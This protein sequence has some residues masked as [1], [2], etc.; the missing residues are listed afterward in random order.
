MGIYIDDKLKFHI[1]IK[2]LIEKL[3][4][5]LNVLK[6]VAGSIWGGHPTTLLKVL[7]AT[8]RSVIYGCSI[9]DS[10][11]STLLRKLDSTYNRGLR[12]CMRFIRS[13]PINALQVETGL[14]PLHTRRRW[15][16][17]KEIFKSMSLGLHIVKYI[18]T[19]SSLD[20]LNKCAYTY[21]ERVCFE[22]K[23]IINGI[24][25]SSIMSKPT[26]LRIEADLELGHTLYKKQLND[27]QWKHLGDTVIQERYEGYHKYY[28][29]A[30]KR[31]NQTGI[32]VTDL[33][34]NGCSLVINDRIQITNAEMVAILKAIIISEERD[35]QNIVILSDYKEGCDWLN[36]GIFDNYLVYTVWAEI[37]K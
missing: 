3:E 37:S 18:S 7:Q 20:S 21:L 8:V 35:H 24:G 14:M 2:Q 34:G 16:T 31:N 17:Q 19:A 10:A 6:M 5:R 15:L 30:S 9:Y 1:H 23:E 27:K 22:A 32:G 29:D 13:T 33:R 12:I 11:S 26:N 28:T 36:R 25:H 4:P